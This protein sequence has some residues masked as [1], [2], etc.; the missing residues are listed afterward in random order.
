MKIQAL[1]ALASET[2]AAYVQVRD[3]YHRVLLVTGEDSSLLR[4]QQFFSAN[5]FEDAPLTPKPYEPVAPYAR[6]SFNGEGEFACTLSAVETDTPGRKSVEV[7]LENGA[8]T[9]WFALEFE[10]PWRDI[11]DSSTVTSGLFLQ[12]GKAVDYRFDIFYWTIDGTRHSLFDSPITRTGS[13]SQNSI[14]FDGEYSLP[15]RQQIDFNRD[16]VAAFFFEP[17]MSEIS[18]IDVYVGFGQ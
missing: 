1:D 15:S 3:L 8:E 13:E 2:H 12:N 7:K 17:E 14:R 18:L 10:L 16:P 4:C 11:R 5:L 6:V 9:G